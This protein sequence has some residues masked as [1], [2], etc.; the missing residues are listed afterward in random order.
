MEREAYTKHFALDR[1]HF[2]RR[3]KRK[4]ILEQLDQ[5][6]SAHRA[7]RILDVGGAC[8]VLSQ[9]MRRFGQVWVVEPDEDIVKQA[10][11]QLDVAVLRGWLPDNLPVMEAC[12]V[13]TL[14]DVLEHVEDDEASLSALYSVLR[15]DGVFVCT[16]PALPALWSE[17]DEALHHKRRYTRRALEEKLMHAGFQVERITY[18]TSFLLPLVWVQRRAN[19]WRRGPSPARYKVTVPHP[20][21]NDALGRVMG[22]ERLFLRHFNLPIG[23]SLLAICRKPA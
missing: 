10:R 7:R 18:Y 17:H 9:E 22:F 15:E 6:L 13:I 21:V 23:S 14:L 12:D 5:V 2:W 11:E 3:A 8:S 4:L 20:F 19:E 1:D 16:V